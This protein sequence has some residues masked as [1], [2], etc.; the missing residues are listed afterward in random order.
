M[1]W[2]GG[3]GLRA[4]HGCASHLRTVEGKRVDFSVV[5]GNITVPIQNAHMPNV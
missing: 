5:S 3:G 4:E 2:G 1:V